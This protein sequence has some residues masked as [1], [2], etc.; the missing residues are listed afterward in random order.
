[1]RARRPAAGLSAAVLAAL[2]LLT[3]CG[4][5]GADDAGIANPAAV[6]CEEQGGTVSGEEPLCTLPDGTVVDAWEHYREA[7]PEPSD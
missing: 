2:T 3:G 5:D 7:N 1:M 6:Y 4:D